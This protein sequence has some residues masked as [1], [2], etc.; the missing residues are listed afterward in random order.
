[1]LLFDEKREMRRTWNPFLWSWPW[2]LLGEDV[3]LGN[4]WG[5]LLLPNVWIFF[6]PSNAPTRHFL[7]SFG[8]NVFSWPSSR[9]SKQVMISPYLA[10]ET[11]L[12][13]CSFFTYYGW[14]GFWELSEKQSLEMKGSWALWHREETSS[15]LN[16]LPPILIR[17]WCI[18]EK[19]Y[20]S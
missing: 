4:C 18:R 5:D 9:S 8:V 13:C 3:V 1:M 11:S 12:F 17:I 2:I 19:Y 6:G 7:A 14:K 15:L 10:H 20:H 16:F